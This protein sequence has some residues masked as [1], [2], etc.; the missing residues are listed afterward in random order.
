[1]HKHLKLNGGYVDLRSSSTFNINAHPRL[2]NVLA[3]EFERKL[4]V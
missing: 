4:D 1:M 3:V 2:R